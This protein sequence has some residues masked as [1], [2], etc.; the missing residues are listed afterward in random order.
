MTSA[1]SITR[2]LA[3]SLARAVMVFF[4]LSVTLRRMPPGQGNRIAASPLTPPDSESESELKSCDSPAGTPI[5]SEDGQPASTCLFDL[6][7]EV[8]TEIFRY[9]VPTG[10]GGNQKIQNPVLQG[11]QHADAYALLHAHPYLRQLAWNAPVWLT[12]WTISPHPGARKQA[13]RA[14]ILIAHFLLQM[15]E[16]DWYSVPLPSVLLT[17]KEMEA[18]DRELCENFKMME[19]VRKSMSEKR[20]LNLEEHLP[21]VSEGPD[22]SMKDEAHQMQCL[23]FNLG[24]DKRWATRLSPKSMHACLGC[25]RLLPSSNFQIRY[26]Q[27]PSEQTP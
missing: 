12:T 14:R 3:C 1:S 21:K 9:V 7:P 5:L 24:E 26:V 20:W 19:L 23:G 16:Y 27:C 2:Y 15:E 22:Y 13:G 6:P 25:M 17:A 10:F 11:Q 8:L 18:R 4:G